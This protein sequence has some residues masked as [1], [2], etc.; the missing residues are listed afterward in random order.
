MELEEP[1]RDPH[2]CRDRLSGSMENSSLVLSPAVYSGKVS[3]VVQTIR[4][5]GKGLQEKSPPPFEHEGMLYDS[6]LV[7]LELIG[8]VLSFKCNNVK[9]IQTEYHSPNTKRQI[10]FIY[11][12]VSFFQGSMCSVLGVPQLYQGR[13][14]LLPLLVRVDSLSRYTDRRC[15]LSPSEGSLSD[16]PFYP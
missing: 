6:T 5:T 13:W 4:D 10:F 12:L 9:E 16:S 15:L 14:M 8:Q 11:A 7:K 2:I 1:F 3:T